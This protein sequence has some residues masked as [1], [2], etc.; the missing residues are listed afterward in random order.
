MGTLWQDVRYGARMLGRSPGLTVTAVLCMG[1][2]IGA[3]TTIFSV[4][5]GALLRPFPRQKLE[6][7]GVVVWEQSNEEPLSGFE[8][9]EER[10]SPACKR[11]PSWAACSPLGR[12][13]SS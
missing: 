10:R 1:L 4:V 13:A 8:R 6:E 11:R 2:G 7:L 12:N 3:T 5:N 9:R